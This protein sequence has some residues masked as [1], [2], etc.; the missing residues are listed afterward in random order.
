MALNDYSSDCTLVVLLIRLQILLGS[1][2]VNDFNDCERWFSTGR[3][4]SL[5]FAIDPLPDWCNSFCFVSHL[6]GW[7]TLV[8]MVTLVFILRFLTHIMSFKHYIH[9]LRAWK[10]AELDWLSNIFI[11]IS[12]G[13][14]LQNHW[15]YFMLNVLPWFFVSDVTHQ[16]SIRWK[17][18]RLK[19]ENERKEG[20]DIC[21]LQLKKCGL[22]LIVKK[23]TTQELLIPCS[24]RNHV[25]GPI[26]GRGEVHDYEGTAHS[27]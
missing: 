27:N 1:T 14:C 13:D 26:A 20:K 6:C 4:S 17:H 22:C 12:H 11:V 15:H 8:M 24:L 19:E 10:L 2:L 25:A 21:C 3:T 23:R 5:H 18:N 9:C 7:L 16:Y